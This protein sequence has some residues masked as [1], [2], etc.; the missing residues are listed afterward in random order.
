M[1][2][3]TLLIVAA[4][5]SGRPGTQVDFD[6]TVCAKTSIAC[7]DVPRNAMHLRG[8]QFVYLYKLVEHRPVQPY[9]GALAV[10]S[11]CHEAGHLRGLGERGA[12]KFAVQQSYDAALLLGASPRWARAMR[13]WIPFWHRQTS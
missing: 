11:F 8:D 13:R 6:M 7:A 1:A 10:L 4:L 12:E 9:L 3:T 2:L 5:L